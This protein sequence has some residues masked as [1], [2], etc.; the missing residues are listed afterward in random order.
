MKLV[1][2]LKRKP[3][4]SLDDFKAHYELHHAPFGVSVMPLARCYI[5]RYLESASEEM[6]EPPYD[7]LTEV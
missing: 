1:L 2:L 5:R 4:M 7:V 3:G 6:G